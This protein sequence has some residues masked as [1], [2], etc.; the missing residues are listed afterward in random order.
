MAFFVNE[1]TCTCRV[2]ILLELNFNNEQFT[3][4]VI[5]KITPHGIHEMAVSEMYDFA[6]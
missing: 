6:G 3:H 5:T 1:F 4:R 2:S